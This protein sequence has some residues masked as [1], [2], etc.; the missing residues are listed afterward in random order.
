MSGVAWLFPGQD[1]CGPHTGLEL[2][3]SALGLRLLDQVEHACGRRLRG[4]ESRRA[5]GSFGTDVLQPLLVATCL[6]VLEQLDA[7]PTVVT[8]ASLGALVAWGVAAG[9]DAGVLV[10]LASVRGRA[11]LAC[12]AARPGGMVAVDEGAVDEALR[13]GR[14]AGTITRAVQNVPGTWILGGDAAALRAVGGLGR[15]VPVTGAWH[16]PLVAE[17]QP[18]FAA[19]LA[20]IEV[21][22]GRCAWIDDGEEVSPADTGRL[23]AALTTPAHWLASMRVVARR[24]LVPVIVGPSR[25][26]RSQFRLATGREAGAT[27]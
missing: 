26:L 11:M 1:A 24:G 7:E 22:P 9:I 16:T 8:G 21:R 23:V 15:P 18:V 14:R 19:A 27:P 25:V 4:I 2:E 20:G 12:A 13:R 5:F 6:A 3:H 10:E 17:A